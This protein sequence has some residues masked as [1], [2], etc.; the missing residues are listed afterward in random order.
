MFIALCG[1]LGRAS[2]VPVIDHQCRLASEMNNYYRLRRVVD[3]LLQ[4]GGKTLA[5]ALGGALHLGEICSAFHG[6]PIMNQ[7]G[8]CKAR[9]WTLEWTLGAMDCREEVCWRWRWRW[10]GFWCSVCPPFCIIA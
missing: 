3:I 6:I 5:G 1:T 10:G 4:S 2:Q 8:L 9:C 7:Q